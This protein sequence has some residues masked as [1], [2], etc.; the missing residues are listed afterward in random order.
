MTMRKRVKR[1]EINALR[2]PSTAKKRCDNYTDEDWLELFAE[3]GRAG[4]FA[5]EPDFPVALAF[6]RDA[7]A[8]AKAQADPPFD[9][10]ADF[11]P[12]MADM[13]D[14]RLLN[15]RTRWRFPDV[16]AGWWWL[17]E[18]YD[19]VI[20]GRPPVTE[21]EFGELGDWF[22]ANDNRLY[23]LSLPSQILDLG[24]GR[25]TSSANLRWGLTGG[26]RAKGAGKVAE[27]LR[28]LRTVYGE[29]GR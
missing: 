28:R 4:A 1:L 11:M 19:R 27:D 29:E 9:P 2:R 20:S 8:R 6:Y 17:S 24:G 14:A 13:P 3:W 5:A 25:K 16:N 26:S 21:A 23:E 7:L 12:N 22:A 10:P 18:M 15:W